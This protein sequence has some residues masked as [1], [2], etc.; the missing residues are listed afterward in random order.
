[1]NPTLVLVPSPPLPKTNFLF[2]ANFTPKAPLVA[3]TAPHEPL[4]DHV[5]TSTPPPG[6]QSFQPPK[7]SNTTS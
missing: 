7:P 6:L 3:F 1:M 5:P 2:P 4:L